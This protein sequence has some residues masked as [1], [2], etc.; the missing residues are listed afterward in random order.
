MNDVR[1]MIKNNPLIK[2]IMQEL[3]EQ[4][5]KQVEDFTNILVSRIETSFQINQPSEDKV[6]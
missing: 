6:E 1:E 4:E 2:V 3:S 5:R